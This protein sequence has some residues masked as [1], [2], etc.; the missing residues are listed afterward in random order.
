MDFTGELRLLQ[1]K[2]PL[3]QETAFRFFDDLEPAAPDLLYGRWRGYELPAGHPMDGLLTAIR[4]YGKIIFNEEQVHPLLFRTGRGG[5]FI[6]NPG[7][8]PL[9]SFERFPRKPAALLFPLVSLFI[10]TKQPKARLRT[11]KFRSKITAA[12]L[13]DQKPVIDVFARIDD[14]TILGVTDLKW[15]H[16]LGYFF[17]LERMTGEKQ[18]DDV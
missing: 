2:A 11:I 17:I 7:M 9:E 12:M 10:R 5:V 4:W 15:E 1:A 14:N 16:N 3:T 6:A 8:L 18:E 13:Y